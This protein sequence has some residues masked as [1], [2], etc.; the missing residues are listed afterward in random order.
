MIACF[1]IDHYTRHE[2]RIFG[3]SPSEGN[4]FLTKS[5]KDVHVVGPFLRVNPHLSVICIVRDPRDVVTSKHGK[6]ANRY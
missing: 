5:P 4:V 2:Q 6:D 1:E 3:P